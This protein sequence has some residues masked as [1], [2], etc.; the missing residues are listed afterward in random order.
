[1][2]VRRRRQIC[3]LHEFGSASSRKYVLNTQLQ[4]SNPTWTQV[5]VYKLHLRRV[6]AEHENR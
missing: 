1:M 4:E 3:T 5:F 2:V 6:Q